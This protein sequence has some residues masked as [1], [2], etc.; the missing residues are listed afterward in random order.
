MENKKIIGILDE[1]EKLSLKVE[2]LEG[3]A[4]VCGTAFGHSGALCEVNEKDLERTFFS[5]RD[6]VTEIQT[7]IQEAIQAICENRATMHYYIG[8][9]SPETTKKEL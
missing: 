1:L 9:D 2:N 5:I 7:E 3:L 8:E 4:H 6:Q